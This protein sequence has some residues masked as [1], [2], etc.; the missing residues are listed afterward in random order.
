MGNSLSS[1]W[2]TLNDSARVK[3]RRIHKCSY[4]IMWYLFRL[5]ELNHRINPLEHL[6]SRSI[7]MAESYGK[8]FQSCQAG[9]CDLHRLTWLTA[10]WKGQM[11]IA[12]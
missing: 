8:V 7:A 6:Y 9:R 4:D 10:L 12:Q 3:D 5:A 1:R 2:E 11:K